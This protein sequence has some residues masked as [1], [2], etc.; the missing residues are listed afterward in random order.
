MKSGDIS[1]SL[2]MLAGTSSVAHRVVTGK[3]PKFPELQ[4]SAKFPVAFPG[5]VPSGVF[6]GHLKE[7]LYT[8]LYISCCQTSQET[9]CVSGNVQKIW[10]LLQLDLFSLCLF[11]TPDIVPGRSSCCRQ[12]SQNIQDTLLLTPVL[13]KFICQPKNHV[14]A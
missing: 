1:R 9:P 11:K 2:S 6:P 13:L 12:Q 5:H 8:M 3:N 14:R 7:M 4:D 10:Y